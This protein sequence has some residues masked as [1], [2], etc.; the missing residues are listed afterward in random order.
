M[1]INMSKSKNLPEKLIDDFHKTGK[2][3]RILSIAGVNLLM[4]VLLLF[5]YE[6]QYLACLV[7]PWAIYGLSFIGYIPFAGFGLYFWG[8]R[9][10]I[11]DIIWTGFFGLSPSMFT[12]IPFW[13]FFI[14][15]V[16][17]TLQSS[18][19]VSADVIKRAVQ[20]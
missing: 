15:T 12:S 20:V 8:Y 9:L 18:A 11:M 2:Y 6:G 16:L 10:A 3:R 4:T 1:M 5:G 19:K 7:F 17:L 13:I 14:L